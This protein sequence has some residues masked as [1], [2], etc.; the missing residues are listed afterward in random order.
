MPESPDNIE[1]VSCD[2]KLTR[3]EFLRRASK[4]ALTG[5]MVLAGA[6]VLDKFLVP[7]AYAKGSTKMSYSHSTDNLNPTGDR[8]GVM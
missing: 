5:T 6:K 2:A 7:P 4:A 1:K 3:E 8:F